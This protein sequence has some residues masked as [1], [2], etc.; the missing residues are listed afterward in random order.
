MNTWQA[1]MLAAGGLFA[2]GAATFAW[3]RV[4][5]WRRMQAPE[6]LR[7]FEQTLRWTDKV[8]PALLVGAIVG[9]IAYAATTD[10]SGRA[11]AVA[12]AVG[13]VATLGGSLGYLV[14][15][16]R[17]I[18]A[19]PVQQAASIEEMRLRWFTG[20]LGRSVLATAAFVLAVGAV[21]VR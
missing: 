20:N 4:P 12:A 5:I 3:S 1:L 10:G 21:T 7:D 2:G 8:Q 13:F 16:Q 6:F 17:R 15:L 9:S 19:T 14:P 18:I 11:L